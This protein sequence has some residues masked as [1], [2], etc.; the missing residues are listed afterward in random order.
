MRSFFI[1]WYCQWVDEEVEGKDSGRE[2]YDCD[3]VVELWEGG[4]KQIRV[5]VC[6]CW[7]DKNSVGENHA[8]NFSMVIFT[9]CIHGYNVIDGIV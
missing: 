5:D 9:L 2:D 6:W 4:Q 7:G 3:C 8:S 1:G